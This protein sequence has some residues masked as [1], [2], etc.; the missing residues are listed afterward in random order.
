[1]RKQAREMSKMAEQEKQEDK[2]AEKQPE[3][4]PDLEKKLIVAIFTPYLYEDMRKAG[5]SE[6][7][8]REQVEKYGQDHDNLQGVKTVKTQS[9]R[10]VKLDTPDDH[11][12]KG[13]DD[14]LMVI[15]GSTESAERMILA[16]KGTGL[17]VARY[18]IFYGGPS[19]YTGRTPEQG[20]YA[21][22]I[23][24]KVETAK[25]LITDDAVIDALVAR[26]ADNIRGSIEG[27]N[28]K[29]E[30][31]VLVTSYLEKALAREALQEE[32]TPKGT[33]LGRKYDPVKCA[34][35]PVEPLC[36]V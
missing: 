27:L 30:Q 12:S 15:H 8:I 6:Q 18:S 22:D 16:H 31:P 33:E 17:I 29:L 13:P 35:C 23:P 19:G 9:G 21:L 5:Y 7:Y 1:M 34:G 24:K 28:R 26:E 20:G 3:K 10:L 32:D 4:Q 2:Q 36:R 25:A 11:E 14:V